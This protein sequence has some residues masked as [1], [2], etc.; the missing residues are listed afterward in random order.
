MPRSPPGR[1]TDRPPPPWIRAAASASISDTAR[2]V[3]ARAASSPDRACCAST[4]LSDWAGPAAAASDWAR[5]TSVSN[6]AAPALPSATS[7]PSREASAA[8]TGPATGLDGIGTRGSIASAGR[9]ASDGSLALVVA[10][11][12]RPSAKQE[13]EHSHIEQGVGR[14]A[15]LRNAGGIGGRK[16]LRGSDLA[17]NAP[18]PRARSSAG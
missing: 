15:A 6:S 1:P 8:S 7:T 4:Q 2:V 5:P 18:P 16:G 10:Q 11:A 14:A 12:V 9:R 17:P 13:G 3:L